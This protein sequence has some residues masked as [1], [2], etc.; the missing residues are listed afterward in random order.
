MTFKEAQFAYTVFDPTS[1][2]IAL[3]FMV[4][5]VGLTH[6]LDV[7]VFKDKKGSV[8]KPLLIT[9]PLFIVG[10]VFFANI[11]KNEANELDNKVK[12][13]YI[14]ITKKKLI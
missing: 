14:E 9:M 12:E 11:Y 7:K 2:T 6:L 1:Y 8:L 3:A 4:L 5:I 13:Q 10:M